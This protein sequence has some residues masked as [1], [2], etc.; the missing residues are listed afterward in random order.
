MN[1]M[2]AT[3]FPRPRH[4]SRGSAF[5]TVL[6]YS[7]LLLSLV[8]TIL[9]W[10]LTERRMNTRASYF[11]EARNAAEA[12]AEYGF[13]Q[14]ATQFS[15]HATVP[16]FNP[17]GSSPLVLPPSSFFTGSNV[18]TTAYSSS[19]STGLELIGGT[20][21]T[22]PSSG[23]LYYVD[24]ND[25]NNANDT[26]KGQYVYR[27][28]IQV[29]ARATVVPPNGDKP[30][31]AFVTQKVSV[32]GAPLFANAIFLRQ[33]RSRDLPR[34]ADGHLRSGALQRQHVRQ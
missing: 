34:S 5:I 8:A 10:S 3:S 2:N 20:A 16:S 26:L 31:T 11:L 22:I 1:T 12:L 13:S 18:D 30:V 27:R 28:D 25:P 19:H 21:V 4:R 32:R 6:L 33:Q 15:S 9:Q 7:F 14:I 23:A 17:A 24:P 29:L